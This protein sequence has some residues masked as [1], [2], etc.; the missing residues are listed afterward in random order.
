MTG[1]RPAQP[2]AEGYV[3]HVVQMELGASREGTKAVLL[4]DLDVDPADTI[5]IGDVDVRPG[6]YKRMMGYRQEGTRA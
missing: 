5:D 4:S 6:I 3:V 2:D 1:A